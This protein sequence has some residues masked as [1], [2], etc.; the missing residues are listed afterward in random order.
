MN[1]GMTSPAVTLRIAS[2]PQKPVFLPRPAVYLMEGRE[3]MRI[4]DRIVRKSTL[5]SGY[6]VQA[7]KMPSGAYMV[8][9]QWD[10]DDSTQWLPSQEIRPWDKLKVPEQKPAVEYKRYRRSLYQ[11]SPAARKKAQDNLADQMAAL[12]GKRKNRSKNKAKKLIA[13]WERGSSI[14]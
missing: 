3:A 7:N 6:I 9:V 4:G 5:A 2:D 11:Q 8:R 12:S 14:N 10:S 13:K 1:Q